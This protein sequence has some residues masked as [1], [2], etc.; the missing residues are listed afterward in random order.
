MNEEELVA[1]AIE[2]GYWDARVVNGVVIAYTPMAYTF[3]LF[4]GVE[5]HG[6]SHRYCYQ[7]LTEVLDALEQWDG[8]GDPPGPWI[9]VKGLREERLGPGAIED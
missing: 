1:R 4:V 5:E 3:G 2:D 8:Q 9:K 6:Y 7:H